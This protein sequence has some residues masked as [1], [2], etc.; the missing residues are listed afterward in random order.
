MVARLDDAKKLLDIYGYYVTNIA[1]SFEYEIPSEEDF[2]GRIENTLKKYPYLG[3]EEDGKIVG[4]AETL[5]TMQV[6]AFEDLYN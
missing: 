2:C 4:Y 5:W 1:V 3:A 6:K